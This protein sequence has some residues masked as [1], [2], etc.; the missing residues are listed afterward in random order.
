VCELNQIRKS[1]LLTTIQLHNHKKELA[2]REIEQLKKINDFLVDECL[3]T[4]ERGDDRIIK[5][6]AKL[7]GTFLVL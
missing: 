5:L 3:D 4:V 1:E 2:I 7:L 6:K